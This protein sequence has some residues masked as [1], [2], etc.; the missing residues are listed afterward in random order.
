LISDFCKGRKAKVVVGKSESEVK[1]IDFPGIPQGSPL[2]PLLYLW[3]NADLVDREIDTKGGALGFI[4]DFNAWVIG[5]DEEETT[6]LIQEDIIHTR[7]SD[8]ER[9]ELLSKR[10]R[11]A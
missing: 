1:E 8:P 3:Y 7:A 2:S 5:V 11:R 4:D 9:A 10:I 6:K